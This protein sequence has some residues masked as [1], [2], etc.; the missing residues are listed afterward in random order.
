MADSGSNRP[1]KA[2]AAKRGLHPELRIPLLGTHN[3]PGAQHSWLGPRGLGRLL[4]AHLPTSKAAWEGS[5]GRRRPHEWT[6]TGRVSCRI[7]QQPAAPTRSLLHRCQYRLHRSL[8]LYLHYHREQGVSRILV[9]PFTVL[10]F[11]VDKEWKNLSCTFK[12]LSSS[13]AITHFFFVGVVEL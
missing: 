8:Y 12:L 4:S 2:Q 7:G 1:C 11:T 5:T 3:W 10:C 9:Q 6:C 13:V